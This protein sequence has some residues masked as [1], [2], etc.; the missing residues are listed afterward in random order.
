MVKILL[1]DDEAFSLKGMQGLVPWSQWNC[2]IAAVANNGKRALEIL[3]SQKI[4]IVFTDIKMPEMD[5]LEL[6][7]EVKMINSH[8]DFVII[9]GY[10]EFEY[11][12]KAVKYGVKN[13]LLK[14]VGIS[15][16]EETLLELTGNQVHPEQEQEVPDLQKEGSE[17]SCISVESFVEEILISVTQKNWNKIS[18][19]LLL[20]F[21]EI[22]NH[23][24]NLEQTRVHAINLLSSLIKN[25]II[26][27]NDKTLLLAGEIGSAKNQSGIYN[28]LKDQILLEN[29]HLSDKALQR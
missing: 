7:R 14:P 23:R 24:C 4:D 21:K 16:I 22:S 29:T 5:G 27:S 8:I 13:Y 17:C 12:Q 26:Y 1:V 18:E 2:E 3:N 11:A 15:E 25:E 10:G 28:I 9:T 20:F 6:I 19:I